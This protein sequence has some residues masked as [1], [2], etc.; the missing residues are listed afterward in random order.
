[1]KRMSSKEIKEA[2]ENVRASLAV[3]NIEVDEL[4][5]II[6]TDARNI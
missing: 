2:I 6:G 5:V 4:S 3:E 1:M